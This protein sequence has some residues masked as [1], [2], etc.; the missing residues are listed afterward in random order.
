MKTLMCR[1][2]LETQDDDCD[3]II[4]TQLKSLGIDQGGGDE[5]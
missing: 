1:L 5:K 2:N 4:K 3:A